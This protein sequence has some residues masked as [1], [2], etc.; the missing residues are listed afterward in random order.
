MSQQA[1]VE[2]SLNPYTVLHL[3]NHQILTWLPSKLP[4]SLLSHQLNY[5]LFRH[6]FKDLPA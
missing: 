5:S 1:K 6:R 4:A 2:T 3:I